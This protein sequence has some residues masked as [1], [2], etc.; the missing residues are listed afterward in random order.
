MQSDEVSGCKKRKTQHLLT[1][2]DRARVVKWMK[3]TAQMEVSAKIA[4]KAVRHF[5]H[6][7]SSN[8]NANIVKA[9]RLRRNRTEYE[10]QSSVVDLR[11]SSAIV[12]PVTKSGIKQVRLNAKSGR[13]AKL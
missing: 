12:W 2:F 6:S 4:S 10:N 11:G 7:F 13:G 1:V 5:P 3:S 8:D 9:V